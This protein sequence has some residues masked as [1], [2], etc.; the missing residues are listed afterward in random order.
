MIILK[1]I[2]MAIT[3]VLILIAFGFMVLPYVIFRAAFNGDITARSYLTGKA[4]VLK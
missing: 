3:N 1:R 2:G 4:S